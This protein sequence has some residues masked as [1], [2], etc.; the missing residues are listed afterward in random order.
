MVAR[1]PDDPTKPYQLTEDDKREIFVVGVLPVLEYDPVDPG[2]HERK[3][4]PNFKIEPHSRYA[5]TDFEQIVVTP[6]YIPVNLRPYRDV[7]IDSLVALAMHEAG[8]V[9]YSIDWFPLLNEWAEDHQRKFGYGDLFMRI[10]NICE[11]SRV[12]W[13]V[14]YNKLGDQGY[15]GEKLSRFQRLVG[16]AWVFTTI[17]DILALQDDAKNQGKDWPREMPGNYVPSFGGMLGIYGQ[18]YLWDKMEKHVLEIIPRYWPDT[19]QEVI[20]DVLEIAHTVQSIAA[21]ENWRHMEVALNKI[22]RLCM[23]H[24]PPGQAPARMSTQYDDD[25]NLVSPKRDVEEQGKKKKPKDKDDKDKKDKD[26][27]KPP[28]KPKPPQVGPPLMPG[29]FKDAAE[30][31]KWAKVIVEETKYGDAV[32]FGM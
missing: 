22:A 30:A 20:D 16:R 17:Q 10:R 12:N 13:N 8:H 11:D 4:W 28:P 6:S 7:V 27:K 21:T 29:S 15:V 24:M 9:Q 23:K 1:L 14:W 2:K 31:E 25:S 26:G 3:W 19:P 32:Q 5:F 18:G